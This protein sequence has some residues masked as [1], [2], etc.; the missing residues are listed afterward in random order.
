VEPLL[1]EDLV[2]L[3]VEQLEVLEVVLYGAEQQML[4]EA[5]QLVVNLAEAAEAA[6]A[7]HKEIWV[8]LEET[9]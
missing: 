6:E 1:L 3:L 5:D 7:V 4:A 2:G 8:A 9:Q